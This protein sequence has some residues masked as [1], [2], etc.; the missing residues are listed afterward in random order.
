MKLNNLTYYITNFLENGS[1]YKNSDS[2][3][4]IQRDEGLKLYLK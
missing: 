4:Q 3:D 2:W 1:V